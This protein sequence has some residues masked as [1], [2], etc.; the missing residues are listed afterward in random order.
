MTAVRLADIRCQTVQRIWEG[1][2]AFREVGV[3]E[4]GGLARFP[5]YHFEG[6]PPY[7]LILPQ[8][9]AESATS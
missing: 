1:S 6:D 2:G 3:R 7:G 8:P 5:L 9:P 4:S